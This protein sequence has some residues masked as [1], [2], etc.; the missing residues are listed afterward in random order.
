M[1]SARV[2]TYITK[3]FRHNLSGFNFKVLVVDKIFEN[4]RA[5]RHACS[6]ADTLNYRCENKLEK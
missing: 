5:S 4:K 1:D 3:Y 2:P 6:V